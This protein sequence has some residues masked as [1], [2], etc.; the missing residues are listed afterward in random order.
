MCNVYVKLIQLGD[1][2]Y[3]G[4][5]I[6]E[7]AAAAAAEED[8]H[9]ERAGFKVV[10]T[11]NFKF[12]DRPAAKAM[13]DH[14]KRNT[15]HMN[16]GVDRFREEAAPGAQYSYILRMVAEA[17]LAKSAAPAASNND[18]AALNLCAG[19]L[20]RRNDN[21]ARLEA[22]LEVAWNPKK[23]KGETYRNQV[24]EHLANSLRNLRS[25]EKIVEITLPKNWQRIGYQQ[26]EFRDYKELP[27]PTHDFQTIKLDLFRRDILGRNNQLEYRAKARL[28]AKVLRAKKAWIAA[29][30]L[31]DREMLANECVSAGKNRTALQRL[32]A[33]EDYLSVEVLAEKLAHLHATANC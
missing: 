5:G 18:Q 12:P 29:L 14:I 6:A 25:N 3:C 22:I 28:E 19:Q 13:E 30:P 24:K 32:E 4:Y 26:F 8:R 20:S 9:L 23:V 10:S 2:I 16:L 27:Y 33:G 11:E 31:A 17:L 7:D 1:Q 15:M 21:I